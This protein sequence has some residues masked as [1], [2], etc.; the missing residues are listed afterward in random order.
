MIDAKGVSQ[1]A[2]KILGIMKSEVMRAAK[3]AGNKMQLSGR[4]CWRR[5]AG[6]KRTCG[7]LTNGLHSPGR[8]RSQCQGSNVNNCM[9]IKNGGWL[10][11][12]MEAM[13]Q[14]Q[15]R[16]TQSTWWRTLLSPSLTK[17]SPAKKSPAKKSPGRNSLHR[18]IHLRGKSQLRGKHPHPGKKTR[19]AQLV[20]NKLEAEFLAG[21]RLGRQW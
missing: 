13:T 20:F 14:L 7:S 6:I 4:G 9:V 11:N 21:T 15:R 8:N 18:G 5:T 12:K 10:K 16:C 1:P 2:S 19:N 3:T 17:K